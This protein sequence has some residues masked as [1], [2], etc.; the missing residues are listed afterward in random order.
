MQGSTAICDP[1]TIAIS[2]AV[3]TTAA[4]IVSEVRA[5]KSQTKAITTQLATTNKQIDQK[6]TAELNDRQ[7]AARREQARVKVAAGEAGL[8]LGG[9]IDLLLKDSLMQA[10]LAAERTNQNA[11][12]E[13][14][15]ATAEAN[16]MLS[17]VESPTILGAGLRLATAGMQGYA[18]G[19]NLQINR[20]NAQR[21]A[22]A[23][24]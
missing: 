14:L 11:D 16:S 6:A 23:G 21:Q 1:V 17:R 22:A 15:N 24:G 19:S 4:G 9:S 12:N 3:A 7:R 13:R 18:S 8:Q 5:A 10:G 2:L 20:T